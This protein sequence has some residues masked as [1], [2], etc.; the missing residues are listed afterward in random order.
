MGVCVGSRDGRAGVQRTSTDAQSARAETATIAWGAVTSNHPNLRTIEVPM[1]TQARQA[2]AIAVLKTSENPTAA[3]HL[4]HTI[5]TTD[6]ARQIFQ[7]SG[8]E[9]PPLADKVSNR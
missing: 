2:T 6:Q 9:L 7:A 1:F 3:H 8:F 5:T 4:A